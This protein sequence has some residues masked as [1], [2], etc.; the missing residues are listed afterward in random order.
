VTFCV[1]SDLVLE[2][3]NFPGILFCS[4]CTAF[5]YPEQVC[6]TGTSISSCHVS[7]RKYSVGVCLNLLRYEDLW[8]N[9]STQKICT[10]TFKDLNYYFL[11]YIQ[12]F[13]DDNNTKLN[14]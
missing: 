4:S 7:L 1:F 9:I 3:V 14:F 10:V 11:G 5:W 6:N 2:R 13:V 8:L 12:H